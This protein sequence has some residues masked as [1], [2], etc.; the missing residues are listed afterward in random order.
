MSDDPGRNRASSPDRSEASAEAPEAVWVDDSSATV[1]APP[2][3]DPVEPNG[4]LA[5]ATPASGPRHLSPPSSFLTK[6]E[7]G[8]V[9]D[10]DTWLMVT[11]AMIPVGSIV[12]IIGL[13]VVD[14][15]QNRPLWCILFGF[16]IAGL[17]FGILYRLYLAFHFNTAQHASVLTYNDLCE[18]MHRVASIEPLEPDDP[19][20][21]AASTAAVV[22]VRRWGE[23]FDYSRQ[24]RGLHWVLGKGYIDLAQT[25]HRAEEAATFFEPVN[26]VLAEGLKDQLRIDD[27][28]IPHRDDLLNQLRRALVRLNPET[29]SYLPQLPPV[30]DHKQRGHEVSGL[31]AQTQA[32][33]I[34]SNIRFVVNDFRDSA[35]ARLID[36][37]NELLARM[38][39]TALA[40]WLLLIFVILGRPPEATLL[41]GAVLYA[42][43]ATVGLFSR[44]YADLTTQ[45]IGDDYAISYVRLFQAFLLSGHAAIAGVYIAIAL[46]F[47]LNNPVLQLAPT[48]TVTAVTAA[49]PAASVP[50][51]TVT[52]I[53]TPEVNPT[54]VVT[55]TTAVAGSEG[56]RTVMAIPAL[57][58]IYNVERYPFSII[59]AMIFGLTPGLLVSRLSQGIEGYKQDLRTSELS[60][61]SAT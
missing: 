33:V 31:P 4:S 39:L 49:G 41:T 8:G 43:G 1:D 25:V 20:A 3:S 26:V 46:P 45:N 27:S 38:F 6:D 37:R 36:A 44:L 51:L 48:P 30:V 59:L 34:L 10:A 60:A 13:Y 22:D 23:A 5:A 35:K 29:E 47:L 21:K 42:I 12:S 19:L 58:D 11:V 7:P 54:A 61:K 57:I 40:T 55:G 17:M 32:R 50:L 28:T 15:E 24:K 9:D 53:A 56:A 14:Q 18:R 52:P 2:P 16:A